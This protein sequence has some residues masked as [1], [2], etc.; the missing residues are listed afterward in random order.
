LLILIVLIVLIVV[1]VVAKQ[2]AGVMILG[3]IVIVIV[4]VMVTSSTEVAS[5]NSEGGL[6][7][8]VQFEEFNAT[9]RGVGVG[10]G[11]AVG[12]W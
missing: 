2:I 6:T 3:V 12:A 5:E 11:G 1:R 8:G 10:G 7:F 4:I 9:M